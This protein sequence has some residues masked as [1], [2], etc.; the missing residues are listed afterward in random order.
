MAKPLKR[1]DDR[2]IIHF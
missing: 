1:N 2:I